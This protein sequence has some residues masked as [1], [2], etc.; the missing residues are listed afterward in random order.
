MCPTPPQCGDIETKAR[1][2]GA[3]GA[4]RLAEKQNKKT[5]IMQK[6]RGRNWDTCVTV[7]EAQDLRGLKPRG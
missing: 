1:G 3:Q 2:P 4:S 5:T 7:I 6:D